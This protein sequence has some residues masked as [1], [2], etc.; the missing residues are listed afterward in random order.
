MELLGRL[1]RRIKMLFRRSRVERTLTAEIRHHIDCEIDQLIR[2]GVPADVAR[3]Q[4]LVAFGGIEQIKEEVRDARG[5][6]AVEDI[7]ADLGYAVRVLRHHPG[8]TIA[9]V[10]TFGLGVGVATAIFSVVYGVLLR[11]LPYVRP[12]R[13]MTLWEHDTTHNVDRNVVSL[14]NFEAWRNRA[15]SFTESAA[16]MPTSVTLNEAGEAERLVG[17]EV[18]P[19]YFRLLGVFPALGRDFVEADSAGAL[20]TILGDAVWKRRFGGDPAV[21]GRVITISGKPCTIVGVM[22][23]RFEPPRFGW[24]GG[25]ALWFPMVTS[26]ERRGWGRFLLVVGRLRDGLTVE[27]ARA[28]LRAIATQL[29]R[30]NPSDRGWSASVLPLVTEMTGDV[31]TTLLVLLGAVALLLAIAVTNVGMLTLSAMRRR[32]HELAIR[33]AIGATDGR[34]FRQLFVQSLVLGALGTAAGLAVTPMGVGILLSILPPDVPRVTSIHVDGPVLAITAAAAML[35]TLMFGTVA[36]VQG[37]KGAVVS[38]VAETAGDQR[39]TARNG[40]GALTAVEMALAVTLG[41]MA[42]LMVRTVAGLR[43]VDLG[44]NPG[45]VAL[46]R[47]ALPEERYASAASQRIFFER[48]LD[49]V[50]SIPGVIAAGVVSTR[51]LAGLAPATT[52]TD[53]NQPPAAGVP[54]PVADVRIA[55]AAMFHALRVP[56]VSGRLFDDTNLADPAQALISRSLARAF[57]PG[58][59]AV[60]EKLTLAMYGTLTAEVIGVVDDVHLMDPRTPVRPA[61][62]LSAARFTSPIRDLVVRMDASPESAI[63]LLRSAVAALDSSLPLYAVTTLPDLVDTTLASERFTMYVLIAFAISA[64][65]LAAI[66][67]CGVFVG[68]VRQRR[69]EIGIRLALGA[70]E[71]RIIRM[72]LRRSLQSAAAGVA[73]GIGLATVLAHMM[74]Q[75]L[76]GVGPTDPLSLASVASLALAV[77]VVATLLPALRA[78]RQ[79]A[80]AALREG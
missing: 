47:L 71:S 1:V 3:K 74:T 29:E 63:P 30:E 17:A 8:F 75:L 13:L 21:V 2:R 19:G 54:S 40:G 60:G 45:G 43:S 14:E 31:R 49:R 4:A 62:Y 24:L 56:L 34:L 10:L 12:E 33:R 41:V 26:P 79:S 36:A 67:V 11:P 22:P 64:L 25:Q 7:A 59:D 66:G 55:D 35:A 42:L 28:E 32:G 51:P 39:T 68:D 38:L 37:R 77:S 20:V 50:R 57:W 9:S 23:A 46:A 15:A 44:F 80:L 6:R 78:I 48:L 58:R 72:L 18:S 53:P 65:F 52:V 70:T 76:F 73:A 5:I 61:V 69:R 27:Q 16:L